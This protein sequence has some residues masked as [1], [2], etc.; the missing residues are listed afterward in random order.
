M[1]VFV[2]DD[3]PLIR[4]GLRHTLN[5][6]GDIQVVGESANARDAFVGIERTRPDVVLMDLA[7]PGMDGVAAARDL[8]LRVPGVKVMVLTIHDRLRDALEVMA[9]GARG[10]ALKTE[11]LPALLAAIRAVAAGRCYVTPSL[12][13]SVNLRQADL[14]GAAGDV[15][16]TLSTRER[17]V[18]HQVASGST[19]SDIARE[20]CI[21]RKTVETHIARIHRKLGCR[22]VADIVRFAAIHGLLR[23]PPPLTGGVGEP[24]QGDGGAGGRQP[25][26]AARFG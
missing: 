4:E 16:G 6:S 19:S 9:A 7:L 2:V 21:S 14:E 20:L 24:L 5:A 25:V 26:P 1:K 11:P 22:R 17:E 13:S 15:L 18:F 8:R 23:T 10:F 12:A 3:E